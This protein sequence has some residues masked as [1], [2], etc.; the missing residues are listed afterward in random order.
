MQE[1]SLGINFLQR[2]LE[3]ADRTLEKPHHGGPL[4]DI[5]P[6][7]TICYFFLNNLLLSS[8]ERIYRQNICGIKQWGKGCEK[9]YTEVTDKSPP[10]SSLMLAFVLL[11]TN[12][13][14]TQLKNI[15]INPFKVGKMGVAFGY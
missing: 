8:A 4:V 9:S 12:T 14:N 7:L 11:P 15:P 3:S 13:E 1:N 10:I 2:A 5:P 6:L